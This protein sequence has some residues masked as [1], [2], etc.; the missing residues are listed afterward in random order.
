MYRSRYG[1]S[2]LINYSLFQIRCQ[3]R[4]E[5]RKLAM[6]AEYS[7]CPQVWFSILCY[8]VG[9]QNVFVSRS[10]YQIELKHQPR[11]V[12]IWDHFFNLVLFAKLFWQANTSSR[13]LWQRSWCQA[14]FAS[15]NLRGRCKCFKAWRP[16]FGGEWTWLA[17]CWGVSCKSS[18][19]YFNDHFIV[20]WPWDTCS[21]DTGLF[22]WIPL[23]RR[24]SVAMFSVYV[25]SGAPW[26]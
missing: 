21:W 18:H 1:L 12:F 3:K 9:Y 6:V 24:S 8:S 2:Y 15:E 17:W 26:L 14:T 13:N 16:Y 4:F 23:L 5:V 20:F 22:W 19:L 7:Q 11:I 10:R 25:H